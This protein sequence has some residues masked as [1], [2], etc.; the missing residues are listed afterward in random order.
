MNSDHLVYVP[1]R[2]KIIIVSLGIVAFVLSVTL[3]FFAIARG[4][5]GGIVSPALALAQTCAAGLSVIALIFY[6]RFSVNVAFLR[7]RTSVFFTKELPEAMVIVDYQDEGFSDFNVNYQA[8]SVLTKVKIRIKYSRG[9]HFCQYIFS[10]Y[11]SEQ[12]VHVQVNVKRMAVYYFLE[13]AAEELESV[14]ARLAHV[15]NGAAAA[16]YTFSFE[17][18]ED[19]AAKSRTVQL[20]LFRTLS[21]EFLMNS[22]ERLYIANDF[23]SMTRALIRTNLKVA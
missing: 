17:V 10:C 23:A 1:Q 4:V 19:A 11:G 6:T 21:D 12:R 2:A 16:G 7:E 3:V 20:Q 13:V 14:K 5:D 15:V 18:V 22:S 9:L 8:Q